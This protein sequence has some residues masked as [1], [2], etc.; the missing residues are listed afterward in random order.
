MGASVI[1]FDLYNTLVCIEKNTHFFLNLYQRSE[2][3]FG[4]DRKTYR[5]LLLTRSL[6]QLK[7][8]FPP[9][10]KTL[11][12]ENKHILERELN[13]VELY[14]DVIE[15]ISALEEN[16]QLFI[17]SNLAEPYKQP[18]LE[19]GICNFFTKAYFSCDVGLIKPQP[20]IFKLIE[21]KTGKSGKDILMVGDSESS[22]MNGARSM[23]WDFLKIVRNRTKND[24]YEINS[25]K[26]LII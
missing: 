14:D 23:G 25:L 12:N 15:T 5:R 22:D 10:F 24:A 21:E 8:I 4:I 1:V 6:E 16:H 3:G 13:S 2:N 20:E 26:E 19:L 9:D 17:L 7:A 11:Y 18:L